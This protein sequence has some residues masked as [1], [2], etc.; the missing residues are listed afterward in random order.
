MKKLRFPSCLFAVLALASAQNAPAQ[1]LPTTQPKL[2]TI[3]REEVKAGRGADHARHEASWP[4]AFEKAKSPDYYLALTSMTGPTE[5][6]YLAPTESHATLAETMKREDKDPVLSAELA[7]LAARDAEFINA[8]RVVQAVA[9]PDLS[10]GDFPNLAKVRFFQVTTYTVRQ[11][12]TDRFDALSKAYGAARRRAAPQSSYRVYSVIAG[13]PAPTYLV[14]S[15]VEDYANFDQSMADH[16]ATFKAAN[17]EEKAEF[18]KY[19]DIIVRTETNRFRLD[20]G[21]SY[22]SKETRA[23]DPEFWMPK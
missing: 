18:D 4:A 7:R 16:A 15:T 23:Q 6:W 13:M 14:F 8:V 12:Q 3:I 22:V 2:L 5:A 19:G 20:P 17:A 10:V 21:Q 1:G 11:G 9:R